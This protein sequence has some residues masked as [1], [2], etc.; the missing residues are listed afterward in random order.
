MY[1]RI[2]YTRPYVNICI[3]TYLICFIYAS[4]LVTWTLTQELYIYIYMNTV[5]MDMSYII[6]IHTCT[7]INLFPAIGPNC[8]GMLM[9]RR[10]CT[11]APG[12][13][14]PC[15]CFAAPLGLELCRRW[16]WL[17]AQR[18]LGSMVGNPIRSDFAVIL[19]SNQNLGRC[20]LG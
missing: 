9:C 10:P 15:R 7:Y 3:H 1:V 13:V 2:P 12:P 17:V 14:V 16:R 5:W 6:Y 11:D 18:E 20:L 19:N 8:H 4:T